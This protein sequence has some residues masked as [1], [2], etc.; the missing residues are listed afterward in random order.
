[1][2]T[3][4]EIDIALWYHTRPR[5]YGDGTGDCN[6]NAPAVQE[7]FR[8]FVDAGLLKKIEPTADL[9]QHYVGT[10]GLHVY[11]EALCDVQWP[12]QRW[13]NAGRGVAP[14][15]PATK[16]SGLPLRTIPSSLAE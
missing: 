7:A 11:V 2:A 16:S 6:F 9:P 3:P 5:D 14:A 12:Q 4:L 13:V 15:C 10:E 1:M 8:R